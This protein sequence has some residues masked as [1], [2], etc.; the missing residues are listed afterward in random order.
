MKARNSLLVLRFILSCLET[1]NRRKC[2]VQGMHLLKTN[3]LNTNLALFQI[4]TRL[5]SYCQILSLKRN[6]LAL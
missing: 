6:I 4:E 1:I 2:L 5:K 3:I